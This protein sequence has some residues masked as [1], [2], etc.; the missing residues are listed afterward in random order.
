MDKVAKL[1]GQHFEEVGWISRKHP[2]LIKPSRPRQVSI[3]VC[4]ILF[5]GRH[6]FKTLL[7]VFRILFV[8]CHQ[9]RN[10]QSIGFNINNNS[11]SSRGM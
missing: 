9:P 11:I 4:Y 5:I 8:K 7:V 2:L 1:T 3:K 6:N 10:I